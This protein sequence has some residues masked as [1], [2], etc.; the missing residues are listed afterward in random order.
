MKNSN[1]FIAHIS[2][3]WK[4]STTFTWVD[5]WNVL[6]TKKMSEQNLVFINGWTPPYTGPDEFNGTFMVNPVP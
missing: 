3:D 6:M 2:F 5:Q 1:S 4:A